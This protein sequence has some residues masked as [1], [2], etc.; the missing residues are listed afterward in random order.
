MTF[1]S[2]GSIDDIDFNSLELMYLYI[3]E[4]LCFSDA[5]INLNASYCF[6][7][8]KVNPEDAFPTL[9]IYENK[10]YCDL[11]G[12]YGINLKVLCGRNGVGKSTILKLLRRNQHAPADQYFVLYKDKDDNFLCTKDV[13]ISYMGKEV[14]FQQEWSDV[15]LSN[16]TSVG[17]ESEDHFHIQKNMADRYSQNRELFDHAEQ[18]LFTHFSVSW[19]NAESNTENAIDIL[20]REFALDEGPIIG[21]FHW[22]KNPLVYFF[23][24]V[25]QDSS[26][27]DFRDAFKEDIESLEHL[28][29]V[30]SEGEH[31]EECE[32]LTN[33]LRSLM[34][35]EKFEEPSTD[36][37]KDMYRTLMRSGVSEDNTRDFNFSEFEKIRIEMAAVGDKVAAFFRK[38]FPVEEGY[39]IQRSYFDLLWGIRPMR[40]MLDGGKRYLTDLSHG[41]LM[42]IK[43]KHDLLPRM[44][45]SDS[46]YFD[47]DEP[48]VTC[49][50]EW[51]RRFIRKYLRAI[52][53]TREYLS[54]FDGKV[55]YK[56]KQYSIILTTHS[57]FLLSDVTSDHVV[58]L[59]QSD[60]KTKA[61]L[62]RS[63]VNSTVA[64]SFGGNIGE[65]FYSNFFMRETIGQFAKE[66]IE[67]ALAELREGVSKER[68]EEIKML[69]GFVA[70][71]L[72]QKIL[73][74]TLEH[75]GIND[76]L[77]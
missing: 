24:H 30:F 22:D 16:L 35:E 49:H 8:A 10:G 11:F 63:I 72:L 12:D 45:Q 71:E 60:E 14:N 18:P 42:D 20:N 23:L 61:G 21:T 7:F 55:D 40:I 39:H 37:I 77:D 59:E 19:L 6:E 38:I 50:P 1:I 65:M 67:G 68:R 13:T 15:N 58:Y 28:I 44:S 57:P 64:G 36:G 29:L 69:F 3:A 2:C 34:F 73:L 43:L 33:Q 48:D 26:F 53:T 17:V 54:A 31:K 62:P 25:C 51:K 76:E 9:S 47:H 32:S 75:A 56:A 46:I 41:E 74:E 4:Y 5:G 66:K 70:D 52:S 27:D